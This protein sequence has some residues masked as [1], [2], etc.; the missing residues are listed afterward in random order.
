MKR[1]L[2]FLCLS[3]LTALTSRAEV[4]FQDSLNYPYTNGCIE[5]QGQWYCY[6]PKTPYLD[7]LV[8]NNVLLLVSTNHDSVAAPVNTWTNNSSFTFASF[9]IN[10]SQLPTGS[11]YFIQFQNANDTNNCCHLFITT[12]GTVTPGSYR[13]AIGSY[14]T[15]FGS[16]YAPVIYPTDL[17]T[18]TPY[19]VVM[20]WDNS[21]QDGFDL[22][23]GSELWI[24]PSEQDFDNAEDGLNSSADIPG[25]GQ[26]YVY[27]TDIPITQTPAVN[28]QVT[29]IAFQ[30]YAT[31]GIS[32]V[33]VGTEFDDVNTTNLPVIGIQPQPGTNY[34]GNSATFSVVASGVDL[35]YQWYANGGALQDD[36]VNVIGSTSNILVIN[37]LSATANYYVTVTDAYGNS[38]SS[39]TA[40]ETVITTPTAP[41]FLSTTPVNLSTNLFTT[42]S[43]TNQAV[44][45]GPLLYQWYFAPASM[46]TVFAPVSGQ[47]GPILTLDLVDYTYAGNYY[48]TVTGPDGTVNGPINSLTELAP[49]V[50]S[51]S[52]LHTL[53]ISL[54]NTLS[55]NKS[56]T[57]TIN[58]NNV[59]VGGYVTTYGGFGSSY[60]EYYI[61]DAG[62]NGI[63]VYVSGAPNKTSLNTPPVGTY[64][65]V[66]GP[67]VVYH[68]G[69]EI[70]PASL[71]AIVTNSA[72][73][74]PLPPVLGNAQFNDLV[75]NGLGTNAIIKDCALVT[76]TNVYIYADR[77]GTALN[78]ATFYANGFTTEYFTVG[79]YEYPNNTNTMEI[80]Q[81]GYTIGGNP[82]QFLGQVIPNYCSQLTGA[83]VAYNFTSPEL[84]PS[85]LADYVT[86]VPTNFPVSVTESN[87]VVGKTHLSQFNL[88]WPRQAGSTYSVYSAPNLLGPWTQAAYG[89][90]YYPTTGSFTDTNSGAAKFYRVSTP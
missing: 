71:A 32:N 57:T 69:L 13:L 77:K 9:T 89:L 18:N 80:Y 4:L 5:G 82:S 38:T 30:P 52:Q 61:Q 19:T 39:Q 64:V 20:L 25:I 56:G 11:D 10:V 37:N 17:A 23:A 27:A 85:Q 2:T 88:T 86:V 26:G 50:A 78:G 15:S 68:G 14:T 21:G 90:G 55:A 83:Y 34:S 87:S 40:T 12:Q 66:T 75:T 76:F 79:Q 63:Q 73:V 72:P 53:M 43:F 48:V 70:E 58:A 29:Q 41:S 33:M 51:I 1:L 28:M 74:I 7:A 47:N 81:F 84:E 46:P 45:T 59:T 16:A 60:T 31:A 54:T 3:A 22:L 42:A 6:S 44:G 8:T 67:V 36:G 65:T 49:L 24:N 35:T 62:G